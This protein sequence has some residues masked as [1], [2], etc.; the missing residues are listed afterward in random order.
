M[1]MFTH[2]AILFALVISVGNAMPQN[3]HGHTTWNDS[4]LD[5]LSGLL[6]VSAFILKCTLCTCALTGGKSKRR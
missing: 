6:D 2:Y 4:E 5:A 3:E 1:I